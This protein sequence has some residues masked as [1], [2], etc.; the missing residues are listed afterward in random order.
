MKPSVAECP[1]CRSGKD[2]VTLAVDL[3]GDERYEAVRLCRTCHAVFGFQPLSLQGPVVRI[4]A[5]G[6][7]VNAA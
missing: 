6:E 5:V 1:L 4:E 3:G 2:V 7:A